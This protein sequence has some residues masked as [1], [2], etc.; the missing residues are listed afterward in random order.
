MVQT[1]TNLK[2]ECG[3]LSGEFSCKISTLLRSELRF[4]IEPIDPLKLSRAS[5]W[6]HERILV[7]IP[8]SREPIEC[9][10]ADSEPDGDRGFRVIL[11]PLCS[12][13]V[14]SD[15]RPLT[16]LSGGI[17]NFGPYFYKDPTVQDR[18]KLSDGIW[19]YSFTPTGESTLLYP[20]EVQNDDHR[21]TYHFDLRRLD[22]ASFDC[23]EAN[24]QLNSLRMFL[25]FCSGYWISTVFCAG[26]AE[27]GTV[28]MEQWGVWLLSSGKAGWNWLDKNHG[29]WIIDLF[30]GFARLA[31]DPDWRETLEHVVYWSG[32]SDTSQVGP[33]GGCIL[34]QVVL[35][36][37]AWQTLVIARRALSE[38]GFNKLNAADQLRLLL[39]TLSIPSETPSGLAQLTK[40]GKELNWMD[41]PEALV[42]ARNRVVHPPKAKSRKHASAPFYEAYV[43]GKWYRDL[44]ILSLCGYNGSCANSIKIQR[45]VGEI[46]PVPWA[47]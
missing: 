1:V 32:R 22:C 26:T 33:D 4:V 14:Y 8:N 2:I 31:S 23:A 38:D 12:G 11:E 20:A 40:L 5:L 25:S 17:L 3:E 43:L 15:D 39:S 19:E 46:L 10:V 28:A 37:L 29:E 6:T 16:R 36:R 34:L 44:T 47:T 7:T 45:W 21:I 24:R 13:A 30:P 27:D 41:G 9:I 42:Y 35:E 18:F